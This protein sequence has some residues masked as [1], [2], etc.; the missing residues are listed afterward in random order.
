MLCLSC[1][2]LTVSFGERDVLSD[3]SFGISEGERVGIV[4]QNGA[5]KT[6]FFRVLTGQLRQSSGNLY[7]AKQKQLGYLDQHTNFHLDATV[8]DEMLQSFSHLLKQESELQALQLQMEG[9]EDIHLISRYTA[10][11]ESFEASG[12]YVFRQKCKS[13][14]SHLGFDENQQR[15]PVGVLSGGQKSKLAL[16]RLLLQEPDLLL[17][18]EPTNHLDLES[19]VWLEEYLLSYPKT[20]FVISHDRYFL[21]RIA[22][23]ILEFE[24]GKAKLY[25]GNYTKYKEKKQ[26]DYEIQ[27]HQYKSQQRE[28]AR[29][30]A[31]IK[32]QRQWNRERNIIAANS[33]QKLLDKM[34]K[35]EKPAEEDDPIRLSFCEDVESGE[36][37]L[38]VNQ[39][40]KSFE[41]AKIIENLSFKLR[42]KERFLVIGPNGC[43]KSTLVKMIAGRLKPDFGSVEYGYHVK[44]GYYDQENQNLNPENTVLEELWSENPTAS[45]TVIRTTLSL[46]LFFG[47]DVL[48][49]VKSLSGG[50]RARL[51]FAKLMFKKTNLLILDEPTNHLD[52]ASKEVLE[53]A[54]C[55]YNGTILAISHDR[56]FINRLATHVF[57]FPYRRN[58]DYIDFQGT[59][60]EYK[61]YLDRIK[62]NPQTSAM[63][64][65]QAT[66]SEDR[67]AQYLKEKQ[68]QS[69]EKKR[70]RQIEKTEQQI[71]KFELDIENVKAEMELCPTDYQRLAELDSKRQELEDALNQA[72]ELWEELQQEDA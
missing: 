14:L 56:Y 58:E 7:F 57:S 23:K 42:K 9:S 15:S 62:E 41:N 48:K 63:Q 46:L 49:Q 26:Q 60:E 21:D 52:L 22:T 11:Q 3:I 36:L 55:R 8:Y 13:V 37:V 65:P 44:I 72:Y 50:E 33:R 68:R 27:L 19:I 17:L 38:A 32:Q 1:E 31:Y 2:H 71:S 12:G 25:A 45:E 67:K 53:E 24:H 40:Q 64:T 30:E 70:Q 59:Y 61:S 69:D 18:D 28:I 43:G 20:V 5:G 10:L 4:G 47:D 35:I 16:A 39:L 6:T 54:L 51:T 34:E 29:Q 66:P